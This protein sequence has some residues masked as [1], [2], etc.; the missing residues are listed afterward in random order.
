MHVTMATG[1]IYIITVIVTVIVTVSNTISKCVVG[2][3]LTILHRHHFP[4][5]HPHQV[6][7]PACSM[8]C[9]VCKDWVILMQGM[10]LGPKAH[11]P[12]PNT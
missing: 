5:T 6:E 1:S 2:T 8:H 3:H 12:E 7:T 10:Y 9:L 11:G 4:L